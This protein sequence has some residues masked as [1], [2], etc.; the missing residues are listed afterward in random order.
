MNVININTPTPENTL[1]NPD[2]VVIP[3]VY[4][5]K[6]VLARMY[7]MSGSTVSRLVQRAKE[8]GIKNIAIRVSMTQTIYHIESF[9]N[10]LKSIDSKFL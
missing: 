2:S 7:G 1:E 4:A 10:Y 9:E 8:E 5:K 3:I 6:D